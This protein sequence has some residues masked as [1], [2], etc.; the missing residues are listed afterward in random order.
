VHAIV[1]R[2][3]LFALG[4]VCCA[5]IF[6]Q[7]PPTAAEYAQ[8]TGLFAA[9]ARNDTT[10]IA[11]LLDAGEYAGIRDSRGRTPLHVATWRR[12]H[13]AMRVL[14]ASTGD[15]NVLDG[16]GYDIVTIAAV[17]NDV[18][19]LRTALAIGCGPGNFVGPDDSTALIAAARRGNDL[20]V[21]ALIRAGA[22]LDYADK[23]GETA[24]TATITGGDGS[25]R[26]V[27][28]LKLLVAAQASVNIA[29]RGGATPLALAKAR[30]YREMTAILETAGA[31]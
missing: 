12:R 2:C 28:T 7:V 20:P 4:L 30:G 11:K 16:D 27:A 3:A 22:Q 8:Y 19:T 29:D 18:D 5:P 26:Y 6:A 24:L 1:R 10:R 13:D 31:R 21:R 17:A 15:P 9:A 23:R 25:K 14:A